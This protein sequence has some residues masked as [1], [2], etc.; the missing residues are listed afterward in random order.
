MNLTKKLLLA[1]L[2]MGIGTQNVSAH[3]WSAKALAAATVAGLGLGYGAVKYYGFNN[4]TNAA[5]EKCANGKNWASDF[6]YNT[7][8]NSFKNA[9][10]GSYI[11]Q[12]EAC[13]DARL[14]AELKNLETKK[15]L[16]NKLAQ[17]N[18]EIARI[19]LDRKDAH[20]RAISLTKQI[21]SKNETLKKMIAE[22]ERIET[23][24]RGTITGISGRSG[25]LEKE[26]REALAQNKALQEEIVAQSRIIAGLQ[27]TLAQLQAQLAQFSPSEA[28]DEQTS[29]SSLAVTDTEE[30]SQVNTNDG[31][32]LI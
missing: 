8:P 11:K 6:I 21:V 32:E 18:A 1:A 14:Q 12:I 19:E 17:K 9:L 26:K 29:D 16:K 3:P 7:I 20:E 4:L 30:P 25:M 2:I 5:L 27:E 24:M 13:K 10:F 23:L 31:F 28:S 22:Q 15:K